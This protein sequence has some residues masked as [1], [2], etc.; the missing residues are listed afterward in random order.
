EA[1]TPAE[2]SRVQAQLANAL[3]RRFETHFT[4]Q[5]RPLGR[6]AQLQ[7]IIDEL[8]KVQ[9]AMAALKKE[10]G[11]GAVA[12]RDHEVVSACLARFGAELGEI[13]K[14]RIATKRGALVGL[15]GEAANGVMDQYDRHFAGQDRSTRDPALLGRLCDRLR[16]IGSQMAE[17]A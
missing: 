14:A 4:G 10:L 16:E 12:E 15:L 11:R 5:P 1:G 3:I 8:R 9:G 7:R 2:R 6:P 17:V 13:K